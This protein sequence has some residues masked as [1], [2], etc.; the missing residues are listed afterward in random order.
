MFEI[1]PK[2]KADCHHLASHGHCEIL[3][4]D[5]ALVPWLIVVPHTA[6]TELYQLE[7]ALKNEVYQLIDQCSAFLKKRHPEAKLNVAA[8]GN[9]VTQLHIHVVA[10]TRHDPV[11]PGLVWGMA[12]QHPYDQE[13]FDGLSRDFFAALADSA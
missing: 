3:L 10:R 11:F 12:T 9:V 4:M 5:N 1:D 2:L 8:L 7:A 13:A 6:H